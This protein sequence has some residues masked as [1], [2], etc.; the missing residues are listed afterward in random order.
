MKNCNKCGN[1]LYDEAVICPACG[2]PQGN[3]VRTQPKDSYNILW[4]II[5]FFTFWPGLIMYLMWKDV[6]PK[7]ARLCLF[8]SLTL[9]AVGV[10]AIGLHHICSF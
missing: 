4:F 8:G 10:V 9:L 2:C 3:L 5:C 7:R 1:Q 6:T